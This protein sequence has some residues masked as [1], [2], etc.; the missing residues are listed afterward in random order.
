MGDDCEDE[1]RIYTA[2]K[3]KWKT[4]KAARERVATPYER[5]EIS[6]I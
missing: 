3:L 4:E 6:W 2:S 5:G 1:E